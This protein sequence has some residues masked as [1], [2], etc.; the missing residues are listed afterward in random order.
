[1]DHDY[2][3]V[4]GVDPSAD[5]DWIKTAYRHKASQCH[6]DRG[7]T[8]ARMKLVNQAWEALSNPEVRLRYDQ[9]RAEADRPIVAPTVAERRQAPAP[10]SIDPHGWGMFEPLRLVIAQDFARAQF[11]PGLRKWMGW[12]MFG[13]SVSGMALPSIGALIGGLTAANLLSI[14][15]TWFSA[16][17]FTAMAL[18][19]AGTLFGGELAVGIHQRLA[20][21]VFALAERS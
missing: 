5:L 1:M 18:M 9:E 2:Y 8:H 17:P 12:S 4:L 19:G 14:D 3:Q 13:D 7:G 21:S 10:P 6:P 20:R 15:P 11:R 16:R